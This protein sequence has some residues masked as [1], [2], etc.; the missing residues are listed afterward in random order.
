MQA[1]ERT[2]DVYEH[3]AGYPQPP[4]ISLP[5]LNDPLTYES[6]GMRVNSFSRLLTRLLASATGLQRAMPHISE[7]LEDFLRRTNLR[8]PGLFSPMISA[9]IALSDDPRKLNG[10]ER[11][12][13]LILGA[14]SLA[15]DVFAGRLPPDMLRDE[16]LEMGQYPNL[17]ATSLIIEDH[18]VRMFKS[19]NFDEIIVALGGRFYKLKVGHPGLTTSLEQIIQALHSLVQENKGNGLAADEPAPGILTCAGTVTQLKGFHQLQMEPINQRSLDALRHSFIV[20]CLD[21]DHEPA[22]DAE[23]LKCAHSGNYKNR[24]YH[25]SLQIVVFGNGKAC[26]ICNFTCYLDGSVMMRGAAELQ[27]RAAACVLPT[28]STEAAPA[29]PQPARLEWKIDRQFYEQALRDLEPIFDPQPATFEI[30]GIG[31][32]FF[33]ERQLSP[34][35]VFMLALE[36]A[37]RQ[38]TGKIP[39]ITQFLVMSRYRCMDITTAN[40]TTPE[41]RACTEYLLGEHPEPGQAGDRLRQAAASQEMAARQARSQLNYFILLNLHIRALKGLRRRLTA[42]LFTL[43]MITMK[44]FGLLKPLERDILVSHPEIYEETPLIGRPGVRMLYVNCFSMHYQ[45]FEDRIAITFMPGMKWS[46]PN[47]EL[48]QL[49]TENVRR[50]QTLVE[51]GQKP[52]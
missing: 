24:W 34:V 28:V 40:V 52:T 22:S 44:T 43:V 16:P 2:Q 37:G 36:M 47:Q 12:A 45:I 13:T 49:I 11:A 20:L 3:I 5:D 18:K 29:L 46:V 23:A 21:L 15:D 35:P 19:A 9:A 33:T 50:I 8:L 39:N 1:A 26:V 17:F 14:R 27:K 30:E 7:G 51:L 25:S 48:V 42:T 6:A 41:V 10:I 4:L 32:R 38:L 31:R